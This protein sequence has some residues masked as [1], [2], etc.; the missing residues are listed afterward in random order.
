MWDVIARLDVVV[1][2]CNASTQE[3]DVG[4]L[5]VSSSFY[6]F[7]LL[8]QKRNRV[9]SRRQTGNPWLA[10]MTVLG[11][12]LQPRPSHPTRPLPIPLWLLRGGK[13]MVPRSRSCWLCGQC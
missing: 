9:I 1:H 7:P 11:L 13:V 8:P 3:A 12:D 10:G 5:L 2:P 6:P 4:L